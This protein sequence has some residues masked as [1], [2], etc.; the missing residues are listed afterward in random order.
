[1]MRLVAAVARG[2]L[3]MTTCR[4]DARFERGVA[5]GLT[6][7]MRVRGRDHVR[8]GHVPAEVLSG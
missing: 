4:N 7:C 1:M 5:D 3:A 8:S 2:C 6:A